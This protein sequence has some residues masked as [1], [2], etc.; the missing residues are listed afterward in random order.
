MKMLDMV[1]DY[2]LL[3]A[4]QYGIGVYVGKALTLT[5]LGELA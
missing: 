3:L 5:T 1:Q 4:G 2:V